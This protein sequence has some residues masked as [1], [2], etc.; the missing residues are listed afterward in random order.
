[1]SYSVSIASDSISNAVTFL[2]YLIKWGYYNG[3]KYEAAIEYI[4]VPAQKS[5]T[6]LP[7]SEFSTSYNIENE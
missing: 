2:I 1:L 6:D 5:P 3:L 4:P 7:S